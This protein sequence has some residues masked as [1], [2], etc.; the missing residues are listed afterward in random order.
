MSTGASAV[1]SAPSRRTLAR[2]A[3]LLGPQRR[4]CAVLVLAIAVSAA[5]G[6]APAFLV[7]QALQAFGHGD[8]TEV[9]LAAAGMVLAAIL[10]ALLGIGQTL[11]TNRIAQR[12][13]HD[14]RA[15]VF[16]HL[17]RLSLAFFTRT[18]SGDVQSRIAN[19]IGG[20][21]DV[22][23]T[24]AA[25]LVSSAL[26]ILAG[27]AAMLYLNWKLALF[28]FAL[29]PPS[30]FLQRH[31]GGERR[32]LA[33]QAQETRA[34]IAAH[35]EESLSV[36][37]ILLGKSLAADAA[38]AERFEA[39]SSRLAE[40]EVRRRMAG[41]W[42]IAA[43]QTSFA[44]IPAAVYVYAGYVTGGISVP[45]LVAFTTLQLRLFS[46]VMSLL[47]GG[48]DLQAALALFDRIFAYL[49]EPIDIVE[50]PG[51][52]SAAPSGDVAFDRVWFR[53]GE[54]WTLRD[55]SFVVPEGTTTAIVGETGSG[56]TT[57]GYLAARLYDVARG[58]VTIGGADV[59]D[60]T[61]AAIAELVGVVSQ[62]TYLFH[63]SVRDN[64]RFAR[65]GASDE[66]LEQAARAAHIHETLVR[67]PEG[68]DTVVG[69]RG[70]ALSGG[71]RQRLAIA[72]TLLRNPPVLV[73]D[74]PTSFLDTE[75]ARRVHATLE[76]LSAG[77]T[78][79]MIA[80]RLSSVRSADQIVVL[81]R[82]RVVEVGR[83]DELLSAC[84]RYAALAADEG[85]EL[86]GVA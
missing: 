46:P 74:E 14:L 16:R 80:H 64:L 67:L 18:R 72:R 12:V 52:L 7:K 34:D 13:M 48:L 51:A 20:V 25:S 78:T 15:A 30:V 61:F 70:Y 44:A 47:R 4:R 38:L 21:Q 1:V 79:I 49:D 86:T 45:T 55:V 24:T 82:G 50:R 22:L 41:R 53:Y 31:V 84:G 8:T 33:R 59:R 60:L 9:S 68:Y 63:S 56:K 81:E 62:E 66:E 36:A 27:L 73:L 69:A 35:V 75:T 57:L 32:G 19:D 77:R 42:S 40:L 28:G 43:L 58:R 37:G 85:F 65:P 5:V 54:D 10:L 76:E 17:Q 6:V 2:A 39:Y 83:H 26:T 23:T 29:L 3:R 11:L 71:E